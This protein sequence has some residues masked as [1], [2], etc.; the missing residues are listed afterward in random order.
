MSR[1]FVFNPEH[2]YALADSHKQYYPPAGII[3]LRRRFQ[4][5]NVFETSE[6]D[7]ILTDDSKI[8]SALS[9][10]KIPLN[11]ALVM[12]NSVQ[13]WGWDAAVK[14]QM[15]K[16]GFSPEIMPSEEY[17]RKLR[18][19]SHRRISITFNDHLNSPYIPREFFSLEEAQAFLNE[20][21]DCC[22]KAPWSS[23]GRGVMFCKDLSRQT[24]LER[25]H[26]I[27]NK[28][29]SVM[30]ETTAKKSLDFATLW[31]ARNG[32]IYFRGFSVTLT[33]KRGRYL[34]NLYGSNQELLEYIMR[35]S[36]GLDQRLIESQKRYLQEN[37]A[38][39]YSGR[40]GIDMIADV[41]GNIRPC[42]ELNLRNTMG[43]VAI[44]IDLMLKSGK[45]SDFQKQIL[46]EYADNFISVK[47]RL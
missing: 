41:Y 12:V 42:I 30:A 22:F 44:D 11:D 16:M 26:G 46:K 36:E 40:L 5:I 19:L 3:N 23:S 43:H 20:N 45:T 32:N 7:F 15:I 27:I 39:Y 14:N 10:T 17:I 37:I 33:D 25:L 13:P 6:N 21:P 2:D 47:T 1:L 29:G 35:F 24:V 18:D 31:I 34:A 28:Q 9:S 8:V 4:F 38:P